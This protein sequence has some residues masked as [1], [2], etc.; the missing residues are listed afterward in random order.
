MLGSSAEPQLAAPLANFFKDVHMIKY[1]ATAMTHIGKLLWDLGCKSSVSNIIR[2]TQ[3]C[4]GNLKNMSTSSESWRVHYAPG[5]RRELLSFRGQRQLAGVLD[6][7]K[8]HDSHLPASFWPFVSYLLEN[9]QRAFPDEPALRKWETLPRRSPDDDNEMETAQYQTNG[10]MYPFRP[11][12]RPRG[13]FQALEQ[14]RANACRHKFPSHRK[15]TGGVMSSFCPHQVSIQA[16]FFPPTYR[17]TPTIDAEL[18][19]AKEVT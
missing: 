7:F 8:D 5:V 2:P 17:E 1:P 4:S 12:Q 19:F 11:R 14:E 16:R 15:R 10:K 6:S 9:S 3:Q 18:R 13:Y